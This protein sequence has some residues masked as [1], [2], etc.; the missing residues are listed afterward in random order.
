MEVE[1][2]IAQFGLA[3]IAAIALTQIVKKFIKLS[4]AAKPVVAMALG[5][6]V[7]AVFGHF[8]GECQVWDCAV[9][10]ITVGLGVGAVSGWSATGL[11]QFITKTLSA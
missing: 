3:G 1:Q 2:L 10:A 7:S 9:K 6:I 5:M 4:R 8:A 11:H